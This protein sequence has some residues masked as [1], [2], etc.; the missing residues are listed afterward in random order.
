LSQV[1]V[2]AG[3]T[4]AGKTDAAIAVARR[5]D[6][7]VVSADA[8]Q[9]YRGMD[10]GT[11]KPTLEERAG[12]QHFGLDVVRPDEPFD[13][14]AFVQLAD[15]VVARHPRVIL[16]G[17]TAL[18]LR[19]FVRGLVE[20]PPVDPALRARLEALDD[21]WSAL[22][23]VDPALAARLHPNDRL[24][25]VRGLE[26]F[27][28][29]GGPLSALHDAHAQAPDRVPVSA[30]WLDREDLEARIDVRVLA[31]MDQGYL[32]EVQTLLNAGFSRDL[33]PMGSLGYRHLADHLVGDLP[34][35]EAVRLTQRDTR[36]FA[37]KQRTW[38]R[39]LGWPRVFPHEIDRIHA[40]AQRVFASGVPGAAF[41]R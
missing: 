19:S 2:I 35:A 9:V 20:T 39:G 23:E 4:A 34:L 1:L 27:H 11:A 22:N 16:C 13:A 18:Y 33:K 10:V 8:M 17:G 30:F 7:V 26:V 5:F 28:A 21:P 29:S 15:E 14:A 6:A 41:P 31:M 12:I 25:L 40:E 32:D 3:P 37:R 38:M 36:H 24:R